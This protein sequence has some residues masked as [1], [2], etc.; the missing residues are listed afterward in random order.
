MIYPYSPADREGVLTIFRMNTP[1]YF[2]PEE[3][4]DL[5]QYLEEH[6]AHYFVYKKA[7]QV[8]GAGGY[9]YQ[10][11]QGRLSW[12]FTH[13]AY[14]GQGIGGMLARNAL[15]Q[16]KQHQ[17]LESIMVRTTQHAHAFFARFGFELEYVEKDFWAKGLDLYRMVLPLQA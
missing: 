6:S 17:P 10:R 1:L 8:V 15:L 13:P 4:A 14:Q 11:P 12:Y 9:N 7:G 2:A 5:Q 3:E 16:L